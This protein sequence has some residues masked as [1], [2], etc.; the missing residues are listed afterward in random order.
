MDDHLNDEKL[1]LKVY[2]QFDVT[3][4]WS[5]YFVS[6][7]LN[8][9]H[10]LCFIQVLQVIRGDILPHSHVLPRDFL[11]RIM[12]LLNRGSIH[13]ATNTTLEGLDGSKFPLREE[14]AK[15][16][17]ETLLEFSFS[18]GNEKGVQ[19]GLIATSLFTFSLPA[20]PPARLILSC[21]IAPLL[22]WFRFLASSLPW[23]FRCF[24]ASF[25][26]VS[27]FPGFLPPPCFLTSFQGRN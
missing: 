26:I 8:N 27:W 4:I 25:R 19:K 20:Y 5:S 3:N 16:C 11:S 18:A 17:F 21:F 7:S 22:Y 6:Q 24:L 12:T 14:F 9:S 13:S 10:H 1:D 2:T 23:L 15:S